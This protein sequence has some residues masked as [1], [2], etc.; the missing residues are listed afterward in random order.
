MARS[1][2]LLW[3]GYR[4]KQ[5]IAP[6][7]FEKIQEEG[8]SL[9]KEGATTTFP[10]GEAWEWKVIKKE[11]H[12]GDEVGQLKGVTWDQPIVFVFK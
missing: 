1:L 7:T 11:I 4:G 10:A 9:L 5:A 2:R 8:W 6:A 3:S 12:K